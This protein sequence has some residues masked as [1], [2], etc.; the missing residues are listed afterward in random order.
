LTRLTAFGRTITFGT[1]GGQ[2]KKRI[3]M[4]QKSRSK[5]QARLKYLAIV[6]LLLIM[7]TYVACSDGN[8]RKD[9]EDQLSQFTYTIKLGEKEMDAPTKEIHEKYEAFLRNNP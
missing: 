8:S 6:P 1:Y 7:L 2:V 9:G 3:L 4:L 5:S